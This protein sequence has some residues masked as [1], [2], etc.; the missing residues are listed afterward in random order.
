M[1]SNKKIFL[2]KREVGKPI[3]IISSCQTIANAKI[4]TQAQSTE[5]YIITSLH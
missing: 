5:N 2:N 1:W 3:T 4:N